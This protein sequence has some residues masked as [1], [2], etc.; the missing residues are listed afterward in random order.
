MKLQVDATTIFSITKG[1]YKFERKLTY[2]DL[3]IEENLISEELIQL[4]L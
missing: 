4:E 3:K 1:E 2:N